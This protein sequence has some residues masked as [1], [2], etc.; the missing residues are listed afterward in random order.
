MKKT[1]IFILAFLPLVAIAQTQFQQGMH[2]AFELRAAGKPWEAANM[3]ERIATAAPEK[4]LPPYYVAQINVIH[5]FG[6]KDAAKLAAQLDKALDFINEAKALSKENPD[7]LVLEA[8]WYT[9]WIVYDGQQYGMT[10]SAKASA[11]YQKALQLAPDDP[12]VILAKAEWD[13]GSAQYFGQ[14]LE[15]YCDDVRKSIT[16]F[17]TFEPKSEFHPSFGLERA[18]AI[19]KNSCGE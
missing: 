11:L 3:F 1:L 18:K 4:W 10:Y 19:L 13:M 15:P 2:K 14:S 16:L 9:A 5:S 8:Q 7:I 12:R 17:D 6:E